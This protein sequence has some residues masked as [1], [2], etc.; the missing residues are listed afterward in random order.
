MSSRETLEHLFACVDTMYRVLGVSAPNFTDDAYVVCTYESARALG[1][2]ALR[3]REY[4]GEVVPEPVPAL[5]DV[6]LEAAGDDPTGAMSLY[7]LAMVAGP[8]VLVSLRDAREY[9]DLSGEELEVVNLA[10]Q[11]LLAQMYAVGEV[12]QRRGPIEDE[13]WQRRAR[14]L[15]D[16]LEL[17]GN[18]E[19]FG[20]S[21]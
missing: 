11:V 16:R 4:L 8:R 15:T 9:V 17:A 6:L 2:V 19:S 1:E 7:C 12:A 5:T 3:F 14:E 10:S 20:I 13:D 18:A 21:R